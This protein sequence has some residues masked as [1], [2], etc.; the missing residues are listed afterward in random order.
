MPTRLRGPAPG[1]GEHVGAEPA[2]TVLQ[3]VHDDQAARDSPAVTDSFRHHHAVL[4]DKCWSPAAIP[5]QIVEGCDVHQQCP[6]IVHGV[7]C[8]GRVLSWRIVLE[9]NARQALL[10][11]GQDLVLV[12]QVVLMRLKQDAVELQIANFLDRHVMDVRPERKCRT[13][14]AIAGRA[15]RP[16]RQ[17][18]ID[19][20]LR[21]VIQV[22][23]VDMPREYAEGSH[24]VFPNSLGPGQASDARTQRAVLLL[25]LPA[26]AGYLLNN[27][28]ACCNTVAGS[29]P[30][31]SQRTRWRFV[32]E[33]APACRVAPVESTTLGMRRGRQVGD[34]RVVADQQAAALSKAAR[35][36]RSV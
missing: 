22:V 27:S 1:P 13:A 12:L 10:R 20:R 2:A 32:F 26:W 6:R 3:V 4:D 16:H 29:M 8:V 25:P 30:W 5:H 23:A 35:L 36:P 19:L 34:T 17:E 21:Q 18:E 9:E 33:L 24:D 15:V 7:A 28:C 14:T 31:S 11:P